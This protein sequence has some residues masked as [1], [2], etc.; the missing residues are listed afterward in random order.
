[1][2]T[3]R[4]QFHHARRGSPRGN[5]RAATAGHSSRDRAAALPHGWRARKKFQQE[6]TA[7]S[8]NRLDN[9]ACTPS[10]GAGRKRAL[11]AGVVFKCFHRFPPSSAFIPTAYKPKPGGGAIKG[12]HFCR[13]R[14]ECVGI[15]GSF[16]TIAGSEA[17]QQMN[18]SPCVPPS[19]RARFRLN[20][21]WHAPIPT[22][23]AT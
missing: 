12:L 23:S 20:Q 21:K 6:L 1:L 3:L 18:S 15:T 16:S 4:R 19:S 17:S 22:F 7:Q 14:P 11:P 13:G 2:S 8:S 9:S 5:M 10:A